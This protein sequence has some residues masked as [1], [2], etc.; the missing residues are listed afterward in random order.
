M[1]TFVERT[2]GFVRIQAEHRGRIDIVPLANAVT[3]VALAV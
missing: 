2:R 3:L 1:A